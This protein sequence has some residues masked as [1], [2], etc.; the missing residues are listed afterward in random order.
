MKYLLINII[1]ASLAVFSASI[2]KFLITS[3][4]NLNS[5]FKTLSADL[6]SILKFFEFWLGLF[7][8]ILS[9]I[10]WLYIIASQK[11]SIAYPLQV[12]LS[13][14]LFSV[15]AHFIFKEEMNLKQTVALCIIFFGIILLKT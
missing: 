3:R 10:I 8:F 12:G 1:C 13:L 14:I 5:D 15:V 4:I 7:L 9:Q 6:L 11:L 2:F